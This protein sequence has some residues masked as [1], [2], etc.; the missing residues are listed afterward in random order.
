MAEYFVYSAA[1]G[2][3]DGSSWTDAYTNI[4]AAIT[5]GAGVGDTLWVAHDHDYTY[6]ADTTLSTAATDP[7]NPLK[8]FCVNRTT[9]A[10]A[11]TAWERTAIA[12][13]SLFLHGDFDIYGVN[14]QSSDYAYFTYID[15]KIT[16]DS[17]TIFVSGTSNILYLGTGNVRPFMRDVNVKFDS[18]TQ[19]I[20][21][22]DG[23]HFDW[24][25]GGLDAAGA[26]VTNVFRYSSGDKGSHIRAVGVDLSSAG[27]GGIVNI[28]SSFMSQGSLLAQL[29]GC[30]LPTSAP[31][32]ANTLPLPSPHRIEAYAC[33][34]GDGYY[35]T[36]VVDMLGRTVTDTGTYRNGGATY[37]GT[38]GQSL[39][40]ATLGN[41]AESSGQYHR[42]RIATVRCDANP[43]LTLHTLTDG[44]T[45]QDDE[46][47][48]EVEYPDSTDEAL[49][50]IDRSSRKVLG[51]SGGSA[52]GTASNL[53]TSAETWTEALT[54]DTEQKVAVTIAD[55]AAGEY[56]VYACLAKPST[57][58][59]VCPDVEVS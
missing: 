31:L 42:A 48:I 54:S 28:N 49:L 3:A 36:E 45:L 53:A 55:G 6:A 22:S 26:A 17:L 34:V 33:D 12:N 58:V 39:A 44:V 5:G 15:H 7:D 30:K 14:F 18:T 4:A 40:I 24:I 29:Y 50:N 21:V 43:T 19:N 27:T 11:T 56:T 9:G 10:L 41:V 20:G 37:D 59:Y 2:A 38:N 35:Y 46:F 47:W 57:T 13:Y 8:I 16:F 52:P 23:V 51:W 1:T 32:L 25:G